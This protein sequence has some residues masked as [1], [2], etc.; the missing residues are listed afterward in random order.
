NQI[1]A[2]AVSDTGELFAGGSFT[3]AGGV[4]A[5]N[6]AK[7]DGRNWSALGG[8]ITGPVLAVA[9]RGSDV[10]VGGYFSGLG[11][12]R[13]IARIAQWDGQ[14]WTRLDTGVGGAGFGHVDVITIDPQGAIYAGGNFTEAGGAGASFVAKWNG[15]NWSALSGGIGGVIYAA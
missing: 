14:Q 11:A 3:K 7:W 6:L 10:Y 13:D 4:T 15:D 1:S 8:E 9:V 2:L 12:G 5:N